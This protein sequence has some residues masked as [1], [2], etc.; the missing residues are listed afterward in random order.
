MTERLILAF[1]AGALAGYLLFWSIAA[2]GRPKANLYF[3]P[4][5]RVEAHYQ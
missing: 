2:C 5:H 1:A 3:V 4:P